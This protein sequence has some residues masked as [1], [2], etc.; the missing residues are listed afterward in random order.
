MGGPTSSEPASLQPHFIQ[1][2]YVGFHRKGYRPRT[3]A[4][5]PSAC[6]LLSLFVCAIVF[7]LGY[8]YIDVGCAV[9]PQLGITQ[10]LVMRLLPY[11]LTVLVGCVCLVRKARISTPSTTKKPPWLRIAIIVC[12]CVLFSVG[13]QA[14]LN[15]TV[16]S[17]TVAPAAFDFQEFQKVQARLDFKVAM[18]RER[19]GQKVY[20]EN[21]PGRADLVSAAIK[22][23]HSQGSQ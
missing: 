10:P 21:K 12:L 6:M 17:I 7:I 2:Q 23:I 13:V 20:F 3:S 16:N 1:L 14:Y 9:F 18:G 19:E 22:A 4:M 5:T 8:E 11:I 15:E